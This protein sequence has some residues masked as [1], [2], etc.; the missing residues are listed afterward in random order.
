MFFLR[1]FYCYSLVWCYMVSWCFLQHGAVR[2][3]KHSDTWDT[4]QWHKELTR[5][6]HRS[7]Q[8]KKERWHIKFS[9]W[10]IHQKKTRTIC[11]NQF[12]FK[13]HFKKSTRTVLNEFT[14]KLNDKLLCFGFMTFICA[15][16]Y[17]MG[18]KTGFLLHCT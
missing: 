14:T 15:E 10:K 1:V 7:W 11:A 18:M 8:K 9:I 4:L 16:M 12:A 2:F 13:S 3:P 6:S 17:W 5:V